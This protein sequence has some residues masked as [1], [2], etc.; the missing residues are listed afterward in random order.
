MTALHGPTLITL[1][2]NAI[3][4]QFGLVARRYPDADW[5]D[6]PGAS[7]VTLTL[8]DELRGCIGSLEAR[9]SLSIDVYS[10][11]RA[12]AFSDP[13]FNPLAPDEFSAV[14][15]EVSVLSASTVLRFDDESD[16]LAQL[17]PGIDGLILEC[18]RQRSTFLPQVWEQLP[19]PAQFLAHLRRKAGL[20]ADHWSPELKLSRY[21]VSKWRERD[22]PECAEDMA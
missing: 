20:P 8:D 5:L 9:R 3:G 18:G 4:E 7:F 2:R 11:A 1:A 19:E 10:N 22:L 17:R 21:T 16:A 6:Q 13:R 12:A 14:E 15:V